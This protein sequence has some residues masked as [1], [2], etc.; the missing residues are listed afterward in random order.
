MKYITKS[1]LIAALFIA[2]GAGPLHLSAQVKM[3]T[4]SAPKKLFIDVHQLEPGKVKFEDVAGAHAKDLATEKKYGVDFKRYWVD[5]GKGLVYCLSSA[6]DSASITKTH[7]EAHGLL[8]QHV[9]EV[10]PGMEAALKQG[11]NLYLD[12]H[13]LGAGKVTAQDVAA[14]HQKDLAVQKK[15]G[16][17][18]INYWVDEKTGVV[19]C[20]SQAK[21]SADIIKTHKEAHG[22]VPDEVLEVKQ[23]Q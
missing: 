20:L 9:F 12:I 3:D 17:N 23:G 22:L 8:P 14:A 19:L 10:T 5:E 7:A 15:H 13:Y 16:V 1:W 21:D 2:A 18:F 4:S 6:P 11:K